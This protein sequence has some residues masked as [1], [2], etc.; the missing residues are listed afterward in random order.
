MI[1]TIRELT[2]QMIMIT[3]SEGAKPM[4]RVTNK[5]RDPNR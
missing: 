4:A 3:I 1:M 2:S 5:T